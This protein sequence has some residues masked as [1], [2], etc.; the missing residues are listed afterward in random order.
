MKKVF[1][2]VM[3]STVCL[4]GNAWADREIE[5]EFRF[6]PD[7]SGKET[8]NQGIKVEDD[9]AEIYLDGREQ[10]INISDSDSKALFDL[11]EKGVRDFQFVEGKKVRPPYIEVK[12]EFSGEDRE[13]EISRSYPAGSVPQKFIDIQKKYLKEVWK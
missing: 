4:S 13:I 9:D 7:R 6:Q 5:I 12:M 10:E 8:R 3:L 11:V 1:F 2:W